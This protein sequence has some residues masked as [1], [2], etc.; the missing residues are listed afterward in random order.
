MESPLF[1]QNYSKDFSEISSGINDDIWK[2]VW[3]DV[4]SFRF[5]NL[6]EE[7][8]GSS[9]TGKFQMEGDTIASPGSQ[10]LIPNE[11][12]HTTF[13]STAPASAPAPKY[14]DVSSEERSHQSASPEKLSVAIKSQTQATAS[15]EGAITLQ[16]TLQHLGQDLDKKV[17]TAP[18]HA[19]QLLSDEQSGVT[20]VLGS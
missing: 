5:G 11:S 13:E 19:E 20:Q 3:L 6:N 4:D 12:Q 1:L 9:S 10:V 16:V 17:A 8:Q 14:P 18:D 15:N 2:Q 7:S